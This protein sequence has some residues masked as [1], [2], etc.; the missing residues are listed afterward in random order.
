MRATAVTTG[1]CEAGRVA[2]EGCIVA[3]IRR[4][5]Y[6]EELGGREGAVRMV[7]GGAGGLGGRGTVRRAYR[8]LWTRHNLY[9]S[10][11]GPTGRYGRRVSIR[12]VLDA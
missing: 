10:I 2:R 7:C 12:V 4:G 6:N 9:G 8:T 1:K 3:T 11:E 5:R